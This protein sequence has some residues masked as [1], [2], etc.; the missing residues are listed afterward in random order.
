MKWKGLNVSDITSLRSQH[1]TNSLPEKS[2][3]PTLKI[4]ISQFQS[5]LIYIIVITAVIS[6]LIGEKLDALLMALVIIINIAMGFVQ[7]YGAKRTFES[8]RKIVIQQSVVVRDG[9]QL[10]IDSTQ[11]LPGDIVLLG[12]GDRVPADGRL[13]EGINLYITEAILTGEGEPVNKKPQ[14]DSQA[15]FMGTTVISGRG[16]MLV[17]KIGL[18][19]E[20][21]KI[22]KSLEDI[23][24][25]PTPLQIK[26]AQFA[27][28]LSVIII[29]I[30]VLI[31]IIGALR[32]FDLFYMLRFSIVLSVAAIPEGLPIAVTVILTIGIRRIL[33]QNGLVKRLLS[34]ETLG[35]TSVICTDKT[36]T[37]TEGI[38]KVTIIDT[39]LETKTLS[40]LTL[41]NTRRTSLEIAIWE[42]LTKELKLDPQKTIDRA[43]ILY[44]EAFESEKK[45]A[46]AVVLADRHKESYIIG[47]P[48]VIIGFCSMTSGQKAE[49]TKKFTQ[50][51]ESGLRVV[52]LIHK[53]KGDLKNKTGFSWLALV[54]VTDPVRIGVKESI[55]KAQDA[56]IKIKIVTGDF[57]PTA[58]SVAEKIGLTV[59]K[60]NTMEGKDLEKISVQRLKEIID[61]IVIFARVSPH[62]KLKIIEALQANGETVAMMGDGV[63]DAPALK[64]ADIGV[65]VGTATDV[66]KESGDL[67]LLDNNFKTIV[68]ACEE[69]R[70]IFSNIKKV[71]GYVLSN[72]FVE[73]VLIF[74]AMLLSIPFPLTVVQILWIHLVCDGPPDILLGFEPKEAGL[75]DLKPQDI[76]REG[77][78]DFSLLFLVFAISFTVGLMCLVL[79]IVV[80]DRTQSLTLAQS[81]IFATVGSVDLI[82]IFSYK[83]LHRTIFS[84]DFLTNNKPLLGGVLYGFVLIFL[85]LYHPSLNKILQTVPLPASW[86][87]VALSVAVLAIIWVEVVKTINRKAFINSTP[88][89][90]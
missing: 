44:E 36:G 39:K 54:G 13:V 1:G 59:G 14:K 21:G 9:Q 78:F 18:N 48:E 47:A 81:L 80:M 63:N 57:L 86:W 25:G 45:Y 42:Y 82:Y 24:E 26:L 19:T 64:K 90:K 67:I 83:N 17:E 68:A 40:G 32:G 43:R 7:E 85:G 16:T 58:I 50:L 88:Q 73:M 52:G 10:R 12:S 62:H 61:D 71:V 72:S 2:S 22:G 70:Q 37:L 60:K 31:F 51:A 76:K 28:T 34:I 5:P 87:F 11:L 41:L 49:I 20:I 69:G 23:K 55:Q 4:L 6:L 30:S 15:L 53:T 74:G 89:S 33:R 8:L 65:V 84:F 56:H 29:I 46:M 3:T 27:K 79:F 66:A 35:S 38:M 77:V 75:L